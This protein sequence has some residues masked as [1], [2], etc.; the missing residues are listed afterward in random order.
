MTLNQWRAFRCP[1]R[2]IGSCLCTECSFFGVKTKTVVD[3]NTKETIEINDLDKNSQPQ[4]ICGIN[5]WLQGVA[6]NIKEK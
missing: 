2:N 5:L 1:F 4:Y 6:D 3:P